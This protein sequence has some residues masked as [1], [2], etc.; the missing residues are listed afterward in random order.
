MERARG[1]GAATAIDSSQSDDLAAA[2]QGNGSEEVDVVYD[3]QVQQERSTPRWPRCVRG[4]W[5]SSARR[6]GRCRRSTSSGS[7]TGGPCSSPALGHCV[8][9]REGLLEAGG[10]PV[11]GDLAAGRRC[12]SG[13]A[14][15]YP[16]LSGG[17]AYDDLGGRRTTGKLL[18]IPD[19]CAESR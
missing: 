15:R 10:I 14:G 12:T 4:G 7:T 16:R 13:S 19:R 2:V 9:T 3:E 8:A 17:R 18:L 6:A 11:L 1:L 5:C